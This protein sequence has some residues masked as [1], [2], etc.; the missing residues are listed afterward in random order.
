MSRLLPS[1]LI[2]AAVFILCAGTA[3]SQDQKRKPISGKV[4]D[5]NKD[6]EGKVASFIVQLSAKLNRNILVDADTK[7][8]YMNKPAKVETIVE[9]A[10]ITATYN[11]AGSDYASIVKIT[12]LPKK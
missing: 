6:S 2:L 7:Y 11:K 9:G 10:G 12:T 3:E 5:I 1:V 4:V 8:E